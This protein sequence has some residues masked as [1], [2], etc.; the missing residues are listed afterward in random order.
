MGIRNFAEFL[1]FRERPEG[2]GLKQEDFDGLGLSSEQVDQLF[3]DDSDEG[4][5]RR[6]R[7]HEIGT[8]FAPLGDF[9]VPPEYER[10]VTGVGILNEPLASTGRSV[11][12]SAFESP[13]ALRR[14][15]EAVSYIAGEIYSWVHA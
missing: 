9:S 15:E 13:A 1:R 10:Y 4:I 7:V 2:A 11:M 14:A 8:A 6:K 12:E 5:D 3:A